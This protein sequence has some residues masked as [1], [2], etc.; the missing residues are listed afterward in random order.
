MSVNMPNIYHTSKMVPSSTEPISGYGVY[1]KMSD[2]NTMTIRLIRQLTSDVCEQNE[3]IRACLSNSAEIYLHAVLCFVNLLKSLS[4]NHP[5]PNQSMPRMEQQ[6]V[7][8]REHRNIIAVQNSIEKSKTRL[9]INFL[10]TCLCCSGC[11][12]QDGRNWWIQGQSDDL[13]SWRPQLAQ[14]YSIVF[15]NHR[16]QSAFNRFIPVKPYN[17]HISPGNGWNNF[18]VYSSSPSAVPFDMD[19]GVVVII[20]PIRHPIQVD[21]ISAILRCVTSCD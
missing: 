10:S 16:T 8:G 5:C 3:T 13:T 21:G 4:G 6:I 18:S 12:Q 17:C 9:P 11:P 1:P 19:D 20:D 14:A 15:N 2:D 7:K